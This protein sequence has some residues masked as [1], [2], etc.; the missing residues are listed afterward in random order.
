M[1]IAGEVHHGLSEQATQNVDLLLLTRPTT[2]EVVTKRLVLDVVPADAH[3]KAQ[4]AAGKQVDIGRLPCHERGLPLW[5]HQD[6]R[7]EMD[8]LGYAGQIREHH[9]RIVERVVLRVWARQWGR[10]T[11]VDSTQHVVVGEKVVIAQVL[12][13]SPDPR[14]GRRISPK[15]VLRVDN[16]DLHKPSLPR[17]RLRK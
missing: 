13:G 3:P 17:M 2:A 9:E 10:S 1:E 7:A 16:P 4:P 8:P 11:G 15:L 5:K 14:N 6:R 12:D